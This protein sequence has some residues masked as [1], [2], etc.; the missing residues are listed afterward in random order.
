[1]HRPM[2][3]EVIK[4]VRTANRTERNHRM[5]DLKPEISILRQLSSSGRLSFALRNMMGNLP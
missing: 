1:M 3:E 4:M 2:R 5:K